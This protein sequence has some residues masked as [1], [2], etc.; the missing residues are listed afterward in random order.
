MQMVALGGYTAQFNADLNAY[1]AAGFLS[2]DVGQSY[3]NGN[4]YENFTLGPSSGGALTNTYNVIR[5]VARATDIIDQIQ[6][7][8]VSDALKKQY[9]AEVKTLRAFY[10]LTLL[11]W[12][13]PTNVK[14]DPST[15]N[16]NSIAPRPDNATYVGYIESDHSDAI[17]T[18][19]FPDKYNGDAANWGLMSKAITQGVRTRL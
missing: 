15:L 13:G 1:I 16:D 4:I 18:A 5:F 7:N 14:L 19:E 17:G 3:N 12:F 10:M 6:N 2:T 9:I 8:P 11:D